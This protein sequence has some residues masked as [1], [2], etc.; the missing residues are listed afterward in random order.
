MLWLAVFPLYN[1]LSYA[2]ITHGKWVGMLALLIFTAALAII[3]AAVLTDRHALRT[4]V[5]LSPAQALALMYFAWV[6]LSAFEGKLSG[7]L[8]AQGQKAVWMGAIRYEGLATQLCYAAVFLLLSLFPPRLSWVENAAALAL[9]LFCGVVALQYAGLNPLGLFPGTLSTRTNY[10]FQGTI[11]NIDMV[12]GYLSLVVPLL[13]GGFVLRKRGGWLTL[14]SGGLGVMLQ[15]CME[16]QSGLLALAGCAGMLVLL[17]LRRPECR[18]RGT[19]VLAMGCACVILR[20]MLILP[21]LDGA[22]NLAFRVTLPLGAALIVPAAMAGLAALLKH[23]PGK[24]LTRRATACCAGAAIL[25]LAAC[26]A[27]I[28]LPESAGGLWEAQETL[29]G[30]GQDSF[31]SYRLGVWRQTLA[32][33]PQ[34]LL[35]GTGPDT[36]YYAMQQQLRLSGAYLAETY[37]NAHN[38]YL[39]ILSNNG[40]PALIFYLGLLGTLI[41]ACLRAGKSRPELL[42][43]LAAIVC[44]AAQGMFSFSICLVSPMFWAVC[45]MAAAL[46]GRPAIR[47]PK[48]C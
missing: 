40:L 45:G 38:E 42:A 14:V 29:L 4:T 15:L 6:T 48:R 30:R 34:H 7:T 33:A 26:M 16:V 9:V 3:T 24:A 10:E 22:E 19:A 13:L 44:Y 17:L 5:R 36:F 1:D 35:T 23:H 39:T 20:Q 28:P 31:G 37:D 43:L 25:A 46:T 27:L 21:W 47:A 32:M 11:G 18:A 2:H 8:N 41:G 12:S